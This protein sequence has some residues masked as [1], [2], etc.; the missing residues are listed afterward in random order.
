LPAVAATATGAWIWAEGAWLETTPALAVLLC[1]AAACGERVSVQLGPRSWYTA[2][3]PAVVLAGLLGGPLLGAAA[4]VSTQAIRREA[5]WR[6]R[7]AEGGIATLQGLVAG[8]VG[9]VLLDAASS[10]VR[11]AAAAMTAAV[12]VNSVGRFL[13]ILERHPRLL[14]SLWPKGFRVDVVE[15][16]LAV[17]L[18]ATLV[19]TYDTSAALTAATV[20]AVLAAMLIAQRNRAT[21]A[22]ALAA[23]QANARRDQLTGAANRRAFEEAMA[24]EHARVMRGAVPAG[25]Y[26]V[27]LDRF[28]SIN[29]RFG[30][31]VGDHV[32]VEVVRRL[33]EGL[34]PTDLVARWGGEEIA[35]LAPGVKGRR[36]LEQFGERI[37]ML[38]RELPVATSTAV[39]PVTVSV[40]GTLLDGSV[41]PLKAFERADAALYEAKR[42]RD[43][44]AVVLPP[45]LTLRLESA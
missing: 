40:G 9:T 17:P 31:A 36:Q 10:P 13:V 41:Q 42:T 27:D 22:A 38:V 32:L 4:G 43:A 34:R 26:V 5:V 20:G 1:L 24:A 35:V 30:H 14:W 15:A 16:V 21:T 29:D 6:R 19:V 45:R 8:I 18:L 25:L 37:R 39:L 2:A 28:K 11:A 3:T 23:E 12:A 44:T 7:A 33:V